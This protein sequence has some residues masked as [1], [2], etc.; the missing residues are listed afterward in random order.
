VERG[1]NP[2]QLGFR[3]HSVLLNSGV[4][5][6]ILFQVRSKAKS[7]EAATVDITS[8][9]TCNTP[10]KSVCVYTFAGP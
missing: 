5:F 4:L 6:S 9:M 2:S 10:G 8:W 1:W 7:P 3:A